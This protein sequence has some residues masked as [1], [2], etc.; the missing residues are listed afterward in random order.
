MSPGWTSATR[1]V[2]PGAGAGPHQNHIGPSTASTTGSATAR[3]DR[4]RI[5]PTT[6]VLTATI[7]K[8]TSQ[9]PPSEAAA[10]VAG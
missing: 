6:A 8:L 2:D 4:N 1:T 5:A 9:T 3:A 7:R 10:S